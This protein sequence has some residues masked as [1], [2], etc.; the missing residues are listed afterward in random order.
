MVVNI[1]KHGRVI[2]N[3]IIEEFKINDNILSIIIEKNII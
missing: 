2:K 3:I 1:E